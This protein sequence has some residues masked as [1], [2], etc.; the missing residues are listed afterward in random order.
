MESQFTWF[1][2]DSDPSNNSNAYQIAKELILKHL[3]DYFNNQQLV[4][5]IAT[6]VLESLR[7][8]GRKVA[9]DLSSLQD[10]HFNQKT[11][12]KYRQ[13][14]STP[15]EQTMLPTSSTTNVNTIFLITIELQLKLLFQSE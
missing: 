2:N 8:N 3:P 13:H 9:R 10:R 12:N 7:S 5:R 14:L 6:K 15:Y 11:L 1:E 4:Q